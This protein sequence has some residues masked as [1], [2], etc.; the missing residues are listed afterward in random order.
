LGFSSWHI[1]EGSSHDRM[2]SVRNANVRDLVFTTNCRKSTL[3]HF[4]GT[5]VPRYWQFAVCRGRGSGVRGKS[6]S[7]LPEWGKEHGFYV[8]ISQKCVYDM[9]KSKLLIRI[10]IRLDPDLF[11]QIRILQRDMAVCGRIIHPRSQIGIRVI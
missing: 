7:D 1:A 5:T 3:S 6:L 2:T 10:Q 11:D 4:H 9:L 8:G